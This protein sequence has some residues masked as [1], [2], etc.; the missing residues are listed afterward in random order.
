ML[1]QPEGSLCTCDP[2]AVVL[3]FD[4][5]ETVAMA[6]KS[7]SFSPDMGELEICVN[8][9]PNTVRGDSFNR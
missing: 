3:V 1:S 5:M 4:Q 7:G 9:M 6:D 2:T 8:A